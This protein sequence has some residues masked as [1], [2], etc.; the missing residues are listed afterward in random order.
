MNRS[1]QENKR[2]LVTFGD[3][4]MKITKKGFPR[5][6]VCDKK[7]KRNFFH[8]CLRQIRGLLSSENS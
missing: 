6:V 7:N 8:Y 1:R 4:E 5:V 3:S 2:I